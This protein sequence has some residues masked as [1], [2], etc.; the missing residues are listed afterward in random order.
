MGGR[1]RHR[2]SGGEPIF[3]GIDARGEMGGGAG[4]LSV[5]YAAASFGYASEICAIHQA[6]GAGV[7]ARRG[8]DAGAAIAAG[9]RGTESDSEGDSRGDWEA[10]EIAEAQMKSAAR[11]IAVI[12]SHTGGEP[13]RVV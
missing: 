4:D 3:L 9:G 5:V 12:D 7:R 8:M 2:V 1:E 11:R 13:T 6:G 10:A